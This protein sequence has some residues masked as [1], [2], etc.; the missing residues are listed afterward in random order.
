MMKNKPILAHYYITYRCNA[1]CVY[2]DIPGKSRR[3]QNR[4]ARLEHVLENLPQLRSLGVRFVD[5]T[6]GE[7]LLHPD[8]PDM[9]RAAKKIGLRTTVTT[10]CAFYP[11]RAKE[12]RGLVDLLHFSLDS[13]NEQENDTLRG[14]GSFRDVMRSIEIAK[15]LGERPDLLFTVTDAN[16]RAID[17]LSRFARKEKLMLIVNPFFAYARQNPITLNALNYL[18][19]F[20]GAPFVYF[21]RAFH[22]LIRVGGND[23]LRPRCRV[24]AAVVVVSPQNEILLPCYHRV[25]R[26]IPICGNLKELWLSPRTQN[27]RRKSGSFSF[28]QGCTIN[29]YFDPSF[30][31]EMD[32]YFWLSLFSKMRYGFDK[33]VRA[34]F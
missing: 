31:Y 5:F 14:K 27:Y 1:R 20:F 4:D 26:R 10:N 19:Q 32:A 7:P 23:R 24:G 6:G 9:L 3:R 21:N 15:K 33:Y 18:E 25:Q 30:L 12:L 22:R 29:C 8:L 2:C 17:E 13:T 28:C 11:Q 34:L 16:Y